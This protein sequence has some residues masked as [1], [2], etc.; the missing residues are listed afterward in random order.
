MAVSAEASDTGVD[1]GARP[2]SD[3]QTAAVKITSVEEFSAVSVESCSTL[4]M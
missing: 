1:A 2:S 4:M 3:R